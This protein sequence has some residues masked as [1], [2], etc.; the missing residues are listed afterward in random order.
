MLEVTGWTIITV[1]IVS[2]GGYGQHLPYD[3]TGIMLNACR[4]VG[5]GQTN[6][7]VVAVGV[8][9]A[10]ESVSTKKAG[11]AQALPAAAVVEVSMLYTV[12]RNSVVAPTLM[13]LPTDDT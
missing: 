10:N 1:V 4:G 9:E 11:V 8:A 6:S 12:Y 7:S 2:T 13:M 5:E 3:C